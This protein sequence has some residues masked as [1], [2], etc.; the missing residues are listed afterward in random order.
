[1]T[2]ILTIDQG[3]TSTKALLV[4]PE[5]GA[6]VGRG[7]AQVGI[8]YPRPGWVEQDATDI[9]SSVE[10][11]VAQCLAGDAGPV[12]AVAISNQRESVVA[13]RASTGEPVG[14]VLGWQDSRTS[15]RCT[16]LA[17]W[18]D[19][20]RERTGLPLDP[21][22]SAPKM[23][24]LTAHADSLGIPSRDLRIGTVDSWLIHRLTGEHVIEAGNASRT[25]LLD[26][27]RLEWDTELLDV[28][29]VP[30][31]ALPEIR[32]SAAEFGTV[33]DM[34]GTGAVP[35]VAV[36]ADSHAALFHH[37]QG[38][39]DVAKATYGT[40]SSVML[41]TTHRIRGD[42]RVAATLAWLDGAPQ[43]ASEGNI[44]TSGAGLDWVARVLGCPPDEPGGAYV[45]ELATS[46]DGSGGVVFVPAFTGLGA[47]HWDRDAVG[48]FTGLTGGT[49]RGHLARAALEAVAHQ[50]SDVF[51]AVAPSQR[52]AVTHLVADGGATA[53]ALL[54]QTQAD[55][56]GRPVAVS[57][58]AEASALG[59]AD[60][61]ARTLGLVTSSPAAPRATYRPRLSET[62]RAERRAAWHA[63]VRR[64][65][66][67]A[68]T[69]SNA[70]QELSTPDP[71]T[72]G[73]DHS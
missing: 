18:A 73:A 1:M 35:V 2:T 19:A 30:A 57:A 59:A 47:P 29:G 28:F 60:L 10:S 58:A 16:E 27:D 44:L 21:M 67:L 54:M 52:S 71:T 63:A 13:W 53:S 66:G 14:P 33:R 34:P 3:T 4:E 72:M 42:G 32:P 69:P 51:E 26:L 15:A 49:T 25:L 38:R 56:L 20:V 41:P 12:T 23:Q 9:W 17:G 45:T 40:G 39:P 36:L 5:T 50:V 8:A 6:I 37:G 48:T 31:G 11:A 22:Y 62:Q 46:E 70:Q 55:L 61:A 64:S 24:W 68:V 7:T 43:Y 65:R